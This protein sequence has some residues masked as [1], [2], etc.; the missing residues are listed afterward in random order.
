M[1]TD[2]K[3]VKY[4]HDSWKQKTKLVKRCNKQETTEALPR[5]YQNLLVASQRINLK[6]IA[7]TD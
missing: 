7:S 6:E 5:N 3:I 2:F 4:L 1:Q